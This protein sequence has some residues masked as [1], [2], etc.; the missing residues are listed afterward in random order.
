[1]V[2]KP[3]NLTEGVSRSVV[4]SVSYKCKKNTPNIVW[5]FKNMQ[6]T[7]DTKPLSRDSYRTISNLTFIGSLLDNGKSLT[8]TAHFAAGETSDSVTLRI[9][10]EFLDNIG[11]KV[12]CNY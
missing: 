9:A 7:S 12:T 10:S 1:M 4:C 6:S 5:N 8:C 11:T 2:E 3:G